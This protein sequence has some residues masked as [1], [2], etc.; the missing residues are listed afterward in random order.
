MAKRVAKSA[1]GGA[2]APAPPP[3][4]S[5]PG[6]RIVVLH[7]PDAFLHAEHTR[8]IR[9]ALEATLGAEGVQPVAYE[10]ASAAIAD[11][12]DEC[13]SFDLMAR[14]K[15]VIV[16]NADK[17]VAGDNRAIMERYAASPSPG[18]TLIL[19]AEKWNKGKGLDALVERL[20]GFQTCEGP[21]EA[22]A[23]AWAVKRAQKRHNASLDRESAR[24]I[25]DRVG[26]DLGRIDT[27]IAKLA[28]A[29]DGGAITTE[30]VAELTGRSGEDELWAIQ[31]PLLSDDP[32]AGLAAVRD[33]VTLWRQSATG[34]LYAEIDLIRKAHAIARLT[35]QGENPFAAAK[36]ARVWKDGDRLA[37]VARR[38]GGEALGALFA[39]ASGLDAACKGLGLADADRAV[40]TLAL[41]FA[42]AGRRPS[43]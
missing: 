7:G 9:E 41:R 37:A 14:H 23:T 43:R 34:A 38:A 26:A 13:R 22:E 21:T 20:G 1:S 35:E 36:R 18:A 8:Q 17:L 30:L 33:A 24:A 39:E 5:G 28:S 6:P 42:M 25:V 2:N 27:E 31:A 4:I 11:V 40:E 12:L 19:R 15:L 16:D 3:A 32:G 29:A 10:G